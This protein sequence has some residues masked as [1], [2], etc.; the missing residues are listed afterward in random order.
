MRSHPIKLSLKLSLLLLIASTITCCDS[1]DSTK[2][3]FCPTP[4]VP[5]SATLDWIDHTPTPKGFDA[6]FDKYTDQQA[7][8]KRG[9]VSAK[10]NG[11]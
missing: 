10:P 4:V 5:D 6:W 2:T 7:F 9:C 8:F 1:A 3:S 11:F